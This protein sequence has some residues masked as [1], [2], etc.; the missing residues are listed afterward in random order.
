MG[1]NPSI[2]MK[3]IFN[4]LHGTTNQTSDG[5]KPVLSAKQFLGKD[6]GLNY[7]KPETFV[8][9]AKSLRPQEIE[10]LGQVFTGMKDGLRIVGSQLTRTDKGGRPYT[11]L[12]ANRVNATIGAKFILE[13]GMGDFLKDYMDGKF[14]VGFTLEELVEEALNS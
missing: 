2:N 3:H 7:F 13:D 4:R 9:Y 10:Q 12:N 1:L 5:N 14:I 8:K 6:E 11:Y